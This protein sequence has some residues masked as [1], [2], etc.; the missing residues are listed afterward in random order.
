MKQLKGEGTL[1]TL[2]G[3]TYAARLF[4]EVDNPSS[5]GQLLHL[6]ATAINLQDQLM[7][8]TS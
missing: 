6:T 2:F 5:F 7:R 8:R 1:S 3:E 4:R